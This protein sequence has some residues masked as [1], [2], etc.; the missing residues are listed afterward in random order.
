MSA[1][2]CIACWCIVCALIIAALAFDLWVEDWRDDR[3]ERR[4]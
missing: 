2:L 3:A 1:F 4:R